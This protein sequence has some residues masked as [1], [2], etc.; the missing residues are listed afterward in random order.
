[1]VTPEVLLVALLG[2]TIALAALIAVRPNLT[3][4]HGGKILAFVALVVL[5]V[6]S[7][8][9]AASNH[10][11]H[12]KQT[13]FCLS[14]HIM[15]PYGRSLYADDPAYVPAAHFQNARIPRDEAC[16]TCHTNYVM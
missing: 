5:P 4:T 14:C 9:M 8:V 15:E 12:S 1:M 2:L 16:Y 10:L 13:Q 3:T 6:L 11:E 7:T